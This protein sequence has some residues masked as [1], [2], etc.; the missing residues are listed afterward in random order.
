MGA[1][2]EVLP[3]YPPGLW[4]AAAPSLGVYALGCVGDPP[5]VASPQGKWQ[6]LYLWGAIIDGPPHVT[7]GPSPTSVNEG[8]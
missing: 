6:S 2:R 1:P 5:A 3:L 4:G 8:C 7:E